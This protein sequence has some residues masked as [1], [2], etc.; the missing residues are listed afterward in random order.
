MAK[1]VPGSDVIVWLTRVP[2][3]RYKFT[4]KTTNSSVLE[5]FMLKGYRGE[6]AE[7]LLP[8]VH[9]IRKRDL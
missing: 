1:D 9:S 4:T 5:D 2:G 7:Q 3:P 8:S 6:S